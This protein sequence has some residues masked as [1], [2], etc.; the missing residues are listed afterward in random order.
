M[1]ARAQSLI[2]DAESAARYVLGL[3]PQI[4]GV[5]G[6][7]RAALDP[8][9]VVVIG[10]EREAQSRAPTAEKRA[11]VVRRLHLSRGDPDLRRGFGGALAQRDEVNAERGRQHDHVDALERRERDAGGVEEH[12][13]APERSEEH[14]S[15]LQ[16][17][18]NLVCRLL[19]EKKKSN[20]DD[21]HEQNDTYVH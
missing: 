11:A 5:E 15:E 8:V 6:R 4:H 12:R 16:S 17:Q 19:L 9:G 14:T 13:V 1:P 7:A 2:R 21:M 10:D 18:S 20:T 3:E